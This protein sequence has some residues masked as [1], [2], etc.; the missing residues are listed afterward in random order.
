MRLLS[1]RILIPVAVVVVGWGA[2]HLIS[3][4]GTLLAQP[5]TWPVATASA[6]AAPGGGA[7]P[8]SQ[9]TLTPQPAASQPPPTGLPPFLPGVMQ[10]LNGDTRETALGMAALLGQLE[11]AVAGDL[12]QLVQ[13]LEPGR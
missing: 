9:A 7:A 4:R 1:A 11:H 8:P 2:V 12:E 10:Q 13:Q 3:G 6:T 5:S